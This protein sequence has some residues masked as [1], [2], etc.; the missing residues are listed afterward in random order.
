MRAFTAILLL[1]IVGCNT[2]QQSKTTPLVALPETTIKSAYAKAVDDSFIIGE[3][4]DGP[5]NI[6]ATTNGKLLFI[7]ND[8]VIV[9]ST[10]P[11]NKWLQVGVF[12]DLS[13]KQ[14]D[15]ICLLK[16][17]K[18]FSEGK[19][20]GQAV[21][22]IHLN[23]A[24]TTNQGLKGEL[25]GYTSI[26][27][28]KPN[29]IPENVF[30]NIINLSSNPL[31]IT[32]FKKLIADFKFTES[33]GLLAELKG[34]QIDENWIDDPSPLLRLWLLFKDDKFY[35]VFHSRPLILKDAKTTK[36]KRR[37]YLST[38][39]LDDKMNKD[40]VNAFNYYIVQVD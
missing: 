29:T 38:F 26:S 36:V 11:K 37:L 13:Q 14:M 3:R 2:K 34:F 40:L 39:N 1:F 30:S 8:N 31:T 27:N 5:A 6:R 12:A 7:L 17:S 9:T 21:E 4:I 15:C 28:I 22:N 18:L 16:G 32:D 24:F 23:G 20:V 35:G 19:E 33:N 25:T 10:N